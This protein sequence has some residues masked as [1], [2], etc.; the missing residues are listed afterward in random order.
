MGSMV[1]QSTTMLLVMP[2]I[3]MLLG[4][5]NVW[6][7]S[8]TMIRYMGEGACAKWTEIPMLHLRWRPWASVS[9]FSRLV[10]DI[11]GV[12]IATWAMGALPREEVDRL[13][14]EAERMD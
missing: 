3:G 9:R 13:Y 11:I 14:V 8:M 12:L 5:L 2:P 6:V 10:V 4:L 1:F 7:P